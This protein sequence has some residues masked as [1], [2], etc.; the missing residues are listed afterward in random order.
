MDIYDIKKVVGDVDPK[1]FLLV[2]IDI[3]TIAMLTLIDQKFSIGEGYLRESQ[4]DK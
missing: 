2:S 3:L 4:G 1:S